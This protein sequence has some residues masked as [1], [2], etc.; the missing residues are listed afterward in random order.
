MRSLNR[1]AHK[2]FVIFPQRNFSTRT[3]IY[4]VTQNLHYQGRVSLLSENEHG[5]V[6]SWTSMISDFVKKNQ[7]EKGID[8]FKRMLM[9]HQKPNYV[10]V[11]SSIQASSCIGSEMLVMEIHCFAIKMGFEIETP[12]ITALLGFYSVWDME[13]ASKLFLLAPDKDVILWS[14]TISAFV[15]V[16]EYIKAIDLFKEMQ[17]CG[18][19]PNYVSILSILPACANLSALRIGRELHGFSIKKSFISHLNIQNSLL[20]MYNKCG[21]LKESINIFRNI[22]RKDLVSWKSIIHGCNNNDCPRVALSFFYEMQSCCFPMDESIIREVIGMYSTLD[23]T[24]AGQEIH[25]FALKLGFLE[26]VSVVTALLQMY[27][28]FGNIGAAR[29][30]FDSLGQKDIIAWSAMISAYAQSEEPSNALAIL[31]WMQWENRKPNEFSFASLLHACSSMEA[32]DFGEAIHAQ[33]IK[34]GYT[35]NAFLAS[36][37]IFM[38]C[39]FGRIQQGKSFFDENSNKDL[40]CWS[41]MINGY[42]INGLGSEA[43]EC[44]LDMLSYGIK[45]NDVVF[46]SVLSACSHCGLEYEGWNWFHAMQE[47]YDITPKLAHYAC[48]VDMLSRQ[49]N[50]EQA[51]EFVNNMPIM[52]DKRIWG[53]LLAGCRK[54]HWASEIHELVAKQLISLDP[55]NASYYVILSNLY[56]DQ[57]RWDKVEKLR[58]L[59]GESKRKKWMGCSVIE[60]NA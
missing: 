48:M 52:P 5:D 29:S 14:A 13:S 43:L 16:G 22:E 3:S 44:F 40:V 19:V 30:L 4:N 50:V 8:L 21:S 26:F 28:N 51:L 39:K 9:S 25:S 18:V 47:K 6:V 53:A 58:Q 31:K 49:G 37:L 41:S 60:L 33:V 56:A 32:Q 12:I 20:D 38:Y 36:A 59:M 2:L 17:L 55:K 35:Y 46:V 23:E 11:L 7:P 1:N 24:K 45:P 34:F 27:D 57:G 42:G 10:T 54:T 15:K